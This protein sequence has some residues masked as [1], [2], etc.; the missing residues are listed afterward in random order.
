MKEFLK[1]PFFVS[2]SKMKFTNIRLERPSS[3]TTIEDL[4]TCQKEKD[5]NREDS[6]K[7]SHSSLGLSTRIL[8]FASRYGLC[9]LVPL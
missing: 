2:R 6:T 7:H 3:N 1:K 8:W 5:L 9:S 4:R